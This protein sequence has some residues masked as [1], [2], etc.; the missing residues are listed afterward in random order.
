MSTGAV[1]AAIRKVRVVVEEWDDIELTYW[2]ED[3]T[4]LKPR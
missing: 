1:D 3:H 4:K 2:R